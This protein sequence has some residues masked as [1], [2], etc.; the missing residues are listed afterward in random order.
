[1][2]V[3]LREVVESLTLEVLKKRGDVALSDM[4]SER[5][6]VGWWL[7]SENFVVFSILNDS[8]ILSQ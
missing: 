3:L 2:P 6:G 5:G 8:M 7:D 1:M 4:A